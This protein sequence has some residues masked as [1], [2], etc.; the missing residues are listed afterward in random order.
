[1]LLAEY[2]SVL[3]FSLSLPGVEIPDHLIRF[4]QLI[5]VEIPAVDNLK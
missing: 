4:R 3:R 1:M 2:F 5:G